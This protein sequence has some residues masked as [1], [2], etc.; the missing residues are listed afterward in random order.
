MNHST[1]SNILTLFITCLVSFLA[2]WILRGM[3]LPP[4]T[5]IP[6]G[7][8]NIMLLLTILSGIFYGLNWTRNY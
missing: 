2:L 6:G 3:G 4:F 1:S 5:M 8:I 7:I